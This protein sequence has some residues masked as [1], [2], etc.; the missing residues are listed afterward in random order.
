MPIFHTSDNCALYYRWD[1]DEG[2]PPLV[3]SNPHGFTHALWQPQVDALSHRFRILRYD[4]R[5]H[6]ASEVPEG[7][8]S[9]QRIALDASELIA[10]LDLPPVLFCGLSIGGMVA[11]WLAARRPH[12][13]ASIVLANTSAYLGEGHPL[14]PRLELIDRQ[15]MTA[16]VPDILARSLS[17]GFRRRQPQL[18]DQLA[19]QVEAM[20]PAG[21]IAGGHAVWDMDLR[22]DLPAIHT[23]ALVV[24]GSADTATP[25][26]MGQAVAAAIAGARLEELDAAHLSNIEQ[27]A[28][29]NRILVEF[30][31]VE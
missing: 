1:G 31:A 16:A 17:E 19:A 5:G 18:R 23:P 25:P 10:G 15:G 14:K 11:M 30:F 20:D 4:N 13:F 9:L 3:F 12:L 26:V 2:K 22:D 29:F 21:Y 27:A 8:Y 24:T 6:G 28:E 7:P